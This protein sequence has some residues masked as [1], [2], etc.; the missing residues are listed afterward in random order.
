MGGDFWHEALTAWRELLRK[1][2]YPAATILMLALAIGANMAAFGIYYGYDLKPLPY[3]NT[4]RLVSPLDTIPKIGLLSPVISPADYQAIRTLPSVDTA[5][6]VTALGTFVARIAGQ[7]R[8]VNTALMTPSFLPTLG[9][10]PLLGRVPSVASGLPG[11]PAEAMITD[12]FWQS[13][14]GG[15]ADVLGQHLLIN[16]VDYAI[17]GVLPR[18]FGFI[19]G[20]DLWGA[21]APPIDGPLAG[22]INDVAVVRLAPAVSLAAFDQQLQGVLQSLLQHDTPADAASSRAEGENLSA[23]P[24]R[25]MLDFNDE[26]AGLAEMLQAAAGFLLVLA[27]VNAGNLA[28]VRN[29]SK[30]AE[31]GL[32][33]ML[34]ASRIAILRAF[35]TEHLPILLLAGGIGSLLGTLAL[36]ILK[37][38]T[39]SLSNPPFGIAD[40]WV[41]FVFAW[42]IALIAALLVGLVPVWQI[43][44]QSI[45]AGLT[46]GTKSTLSPAIRRALTLLGALQIGLAASLL[47]GS[48]SLS[49]SLFKMLTQPLGFDP[50]QRVVASVLLPQGGPAVVDFAQAIDS[51]S[52]LPITVAA[53]GSAYWAYP[54]TTSRGNITVSRTADDVN[55]KL[56]Y[57]VPVAGDFMKTLGINLRAGAGLSADALTTCHRHEVVISQELA[58]DL[59]GKDSPVGQPL[60]VFTP[61]FRVT[62]VAG[63]V[64]WSPTPVAGTHGA[65]YVPAACLATEDMALPI[66]G[67]TVFAHVSGGTD[68]AMPILKRAIEAAVPG[69]LVTDIHPYSEVMFTATAFRSLIAG[70]VVGFACLALILA[71]I[72]VYAVNAVIARARQPEFGM[73][74]MLGA[75]PA[76]QLRT[77][78]SDAA[79]LLA[80]GLAGGAVGGYLLV[81]AMSPLLFHADDAAPFV[82]LAALVIIALIV[83]V[84]AWRP[85]ARAATTSVKQLLEAA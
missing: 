62:G 77:A 75:S 68:A 45:G 44:A 20:S 28:L 85:A 61:D 42:V 4:D 47:I 83:L 80:L 40:G 48:V 46:V 51:A 58:R 39:V 31:F 6:M 24:I 8:A 12:K 69:A 18:G 17:V 36:H 72:G 27:I 82:F 38:D 78:F 63:N 59:F 32:R 25:Q 7:P 84:A 19:F 2:F 14:Y 66:T 55:T 54:F 29:R 49:V 73:R 30:R 43:C 33:R 67:T 52:A 56:V 5:G 23:M 37:T 79:R 15:K 1:P 21:F 41:V 57:F 71:A 65:I 3:A 22:N 35:L 9:I 26:I 16:D 76:A 11:G 50:A 60:D 64:T 13:A 34:G 81:R 70:L 74:A 53:G 10:S